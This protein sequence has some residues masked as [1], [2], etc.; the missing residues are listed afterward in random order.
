[1][2]LAQPWILGSFPKFLQR[3][4]ECLSVP[5]P[6]EQKGI[7]AGAPRSMEGVPMRSVTRYPEL[8]AELLGENWCLSFFPRVGKETLETRTQV[9][10]GGSTRSQ[11]R[12]WDTE[13]A[14]CT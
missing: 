7:D 14:V 4:A 6:K 12:T 1:M 2:L 3:Q 8:Q 5:L 13:P 11:P 9:T 10:I